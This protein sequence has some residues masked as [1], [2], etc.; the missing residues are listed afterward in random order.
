M[1]DIAQRFDIDE[2]RVILTGISQGGFGTFRLGELYP[3]RFSALIPLVGQSALVPEIEMMISG[4]EPF[5]PDTI[6]NLCNLPVRMINGRLDPLK[7]VIAGNVPD[8]DAFALRKLRYDFRYWQ[9]LRRGHEV[10][11]V[12]QRFL[13]R[14]RASAIRTLR[15]NVFYS[16]CSSTRATRRPGLVTSPLRVLG[17]THRA[18]RDLQPKAANWRKAHMPW[19]S[20]IASIGVCTSA[21][22][23]ALMRCATLW[24]A[25][26]S[27]P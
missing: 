6:E 13:G 20:G 23:G 22:V 10:V 11:P 26:P 12:H 2:D 18:R 9:M 19:P 7:N 25:S 3:D 8:L 5:M 4:G 14:A 1:D 15:G 16:S 21:T 27:S 17:L 24:S